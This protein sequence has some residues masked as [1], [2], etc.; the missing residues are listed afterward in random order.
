M[1]AT[2][3]IPRDS[4]AIALGAN[5]V[6]KA[7]EKELAARGADAKIVR[8]CSRGLYWL[9]PMVEIETDAGRVAYGPAK[10]SDVPALFDSNFLS[11]ASHPLYLGRAEDI[12]FLA[13]QTRLTFA[14][15]GITDPVS[16]EDY[17]AHGGFRGLRNALALTPQQIVD[18]VTESG[19]RGRGGAGFPTGIKWKTVLGAVGPKKYIVCN[20]D[21]GDSG[22][23]A[24][25]MLMEGDPLCL[26]EGMAISAYAVGAD[27]GYIY[28]RSEYPDSIDIMRKAADLWRKEGLTPGFDVEIRV[29]AG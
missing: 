21:E 18:E 19:L 24:D 20:A 7:V 8:N 25:R 9:E 2:I 15:C 13:R 4:G 6:A 16:L 28:I 11:G 5:K 12:P 1:T 10:P 3:Y 26:I 14:R 22:S 17:E 27:K 29:G 23:F